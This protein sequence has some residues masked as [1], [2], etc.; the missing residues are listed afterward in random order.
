MVVR[1][2]DNDGCMCNSK[3][4]REE[5]DACRQSHNEKSILLAD[6]Q[7]AS[8][9]GNHVELRSTCHNFGRCATAKRLTIRIR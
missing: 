5:G 1:E 8:K 6:L 2:E 9:Y 4:A 3:C 7:D